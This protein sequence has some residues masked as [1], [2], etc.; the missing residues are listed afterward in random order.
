MPP[1]LIV[2]AILVMCAVGESPFLAP[3]YDRRETMSQRL[4]L[5]FEMGSP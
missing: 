3:Y 5:F 1:R 2:H 4:A